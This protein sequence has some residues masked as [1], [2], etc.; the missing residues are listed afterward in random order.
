MRDGGKVSINVDILTFIA[1]Q[2]SS[3]E[4]MRAAEKITKNIAT[5]M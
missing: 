2:H 1:L 4:E 5:L 3:H